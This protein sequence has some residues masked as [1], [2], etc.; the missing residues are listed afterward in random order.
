[1][2]RGQA[3]CSRLPI[4]MASFCSDPSKLTCNKLCSAGV[5][6]P[7][8]AQE[9]GAVPWL[10]GAVLLGTGCAVAFLFLS[11]HAA[12]AALRSAPLTAFRGMEVNPALSPDGNH[13]AVAW[14]GEKQDNFDIYVMMMPSGAPVRLTADPRR[15]TSPTWSPGGRTVAFLR[16]V[17][18]GLV[19]LGE[20]HGC[21]RVSASFL[22]THTGSPRPVDQ[23]TSKGREIRTVNVA[24]P[25]MA[26]GTIP[27][28]DQ[29][30]EI[31]LGRHL[32]YSRQIEDTNIWRAELPGAARPRTQRSFSFPLLGL[33][34][35][36]NIRP[37]ARLLS[38]YLRGRFSR[39]MDFQRR[40]LE[41]GPPVFFGGAMV[42]HPSWSPDGQW[43][44][45]HAR[46]E[47]PT[48]IFVV[49]AAGGPPKRLTTNDWED[50]YPTYS[51]DGRWM[52]FQAGAP[53]RCRSGE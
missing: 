26:M 23:S 24:N 27:L 16:Q 4:G 46:P 36:R 7:V 50:H 15:D 12:P 32:V 17:R 11:T 43:I 38:S 31:A 33:T 2:P 42:G 21:F 40:W 19:F 9:L 13:V 37:T 45:F 44:T 41:S 52:F 14:N 53:A 28:N 34:R 8:A 30:S 47:G 1:M 22:R 3:P 35:L 25:Q 20:N 18:E 48:D 29:I 6:S 51:R 39:G 5:A 49:P 10:A